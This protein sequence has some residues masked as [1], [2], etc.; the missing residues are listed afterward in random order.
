MT[1]Q[2]LVEI[3][4]QKIR[5]M[6]DDN[7]YYSVPAVSIFLLY[8]IRDG[9]MENDYIIASNSNRNQEWIEVWSC[10]TGHFDTAANL[11]DSLKFLGSN[12]LGYWT[13]DF[14][15]MVMKAPNLTVKESYYMTFKKITNEKAV[16]IHGNNKGSL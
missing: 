6:T 9:K 2:E 14:G 1:I 5:N 10:T 12:V 8:D 7:K 11:I 3:I 4:L 16:G 13:R 15:E